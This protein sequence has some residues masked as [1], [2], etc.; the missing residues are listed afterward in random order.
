M[1]DTMTP[2][3]LRPVPRETALVPRPP[4]PQP[5][6]KTRARQFLSW[7]LG[8]WRSA[9]ALA[10]AL[11]GLWYFGVPALLG[12]VVAVSPVV[13]ADFI[14]SVVATGHVEAP[15]RVLIGSRVTGVIA[16][17]AAESGQSVKAG[18]L[19]IVLDDRETQA[20]RVQA[21]AA[22]AESEA[23]LLQLR[24]VMV[25][26][27]EASL[28]QARAVLLNAQ[29]AQERAAQLFG[30]RLT[31]KVTLDQSIQAL[32]AA[33]SGVTSAELQVTT[34]RPGGSDYMMAETKINQARAALASANARL[35]YMTIAAPVDGTIVSRNAEAGG[36]VQPGNPLLELSP[37]LGAEIVV[38]I[39]E[40][41]LGLIAI[42]QRALVS[43]DAFPKEV[44][45]GE[46]VFI[47]PMID[48]QRASVTVKLRVQNPPAFLR[49]DMTVSIDLKT[50]LHPA[51]LVLSAG[52][53]HDLVIGKPWVMTASGSRA[54]RV[55]VEVGLSG[56]GKVEILKGLKDGDLVLTGASLTITDG[57]RVRV[58]S[59]MGPTP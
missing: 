24:D 15:N 56:G 47:D 28:R 58:N 20:A 29:Q 19:L 48:L 21:E 43:A 32:E 42:G 57:Q 45:E 54:K 16:R 27:A 3:E 30:K 6:V 37:A 52:D 23:K 12:P 39:D 9:L 22:L 38:Q 36:V 10:A 41:N 31:T 11:A 50:A 34:S 49:Q 25:P 40:K 33:R 1:L 4:D 53:V 2:T 51:V 5:R 14:Q 13:R 18:D 7:L 26:G 55:P 8:R 17:I 44:F 59:G 46:V 35:A